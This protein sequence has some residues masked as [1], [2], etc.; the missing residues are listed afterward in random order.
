MQIFSYRPFCTTS[1]IH[2]MLS[3]M[4]QAS[5]FS[6]PLQKYFFSICHSLQSCQCAVCSLAIL[7]VSPVSPSLA[8][9]TSAVFQVLPFS[10]VSR[11][12]PFSPL[13]SASLASQSCQPVSP[14]SPVSPGLPT[15]ISEVT[16]CLYFK[17]MFAKVLFNFLCLAEASAALTFESLFS[18][19][20]SVRTQLQT[21]TQLIDGHS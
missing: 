18:G 14:V 20:S 5:N 2:F 1:A 4:W 15:S 9:L 13:S 16:K 7:S 11:V 17:S 21:N 12:L 3:M 8:T 6:I 19:R 10:P